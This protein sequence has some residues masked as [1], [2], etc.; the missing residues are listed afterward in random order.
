MD[1]LPEDILRR[2]NKYCRECRLRLEQ[3][4]G[5]GKDG[6]VWATDRATAIK[7][8][9][10][11]DTY[12]RELA[13]HRRLADHGV[14]DVLGHRVPQLLQFDDPKLVIE[15]TIVRPPFLLDFASAWLDQQP[16]VDFGAEVLEEWLAEKQEQFGERWPQVAIVLAALEQYGIHKANLRRRFRSPGPGRLQRSPTIARSTTVKPISD[17]KTRASS[18]SLGDPEQMHEVYEKGG[19]DHRMAPHGVY[20]DGACPHPQCDQHLQAIDF[21]WDAHGEEIHDPLVRAW[22]SDTGFAGRCPRCRGWV[23]FTIR[24]KRAI[25]AEEASRLPH[26]PDDWHANAIILIT[27]HHD[28]P[29]FRVATVRAGPVP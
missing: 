3:R 16:L 6:I 15:M 25:S 29:R 21:R 28:E 19:Q 14:S 10:R 8:F 13:A 17:A 4:L 22:W 7:V 11:R 2:A 20:A 18:P 12:D 9:G 1:P 26:L 24:A 27:P 5:F 23:H